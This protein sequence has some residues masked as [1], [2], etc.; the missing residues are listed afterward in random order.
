MF[1]SYTNKVNINAVNGTIV[2][3]Y[4]DSFFKRFHLN[5][6]FA[7]NVLC[8]GSNY[9]VLQMMMCGDMEVIAELMFKDDFEKIFNDEKK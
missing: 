3:N 8:P 6:S 1:N 4:K 2:K 5:S 7:S 9:V